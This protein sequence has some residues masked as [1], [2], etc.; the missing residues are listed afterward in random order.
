MNDLIFGSLQG[1][2]NTVISQIESIKSIM[3]NNQLDLETVCGMLMRKL[4]LMDVRD[5]LKQEI[6]GGV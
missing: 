4:T 5:K 1:R 6:R 3:A 2:L